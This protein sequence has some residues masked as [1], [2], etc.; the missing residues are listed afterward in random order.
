[1]LSHKVIKKAITQGVFI[2]FY[3][4]T[5]PFFTPPL[6]GNAGSASRHKAD[7]AMPCRALL[8]SIENVLEYTLAGVSKIDRTMNEV[9]ISVVLIF[10]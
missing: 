4:A 8:Q 3:R 6:P 10:T 2:P 7:K 1:M 9:K 5:I